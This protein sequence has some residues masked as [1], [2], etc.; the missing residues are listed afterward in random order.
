MGIGETRCWTEVTKGYLEE[1]RRH[2]GSGEEEMEVR[3]CRRGSH[4][5]HVSILRAQ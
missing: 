5:S 3:L 1:K 4:M 2:R